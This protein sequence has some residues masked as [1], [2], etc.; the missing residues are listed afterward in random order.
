VLCCG[1][2][3]KQRRCAYDINFSASTASRGRTSTRRK[4]SFTM[5]GSLAAALVV[6]G[7]ALVACA[8]FA[9]MFWR[10]ALL[11][12]LAGKAALEPEGENA[13]ACRTLGRRMA[14]VLMVGCALMA[15]L[16][17]YLAAELTLSPTLAFVASMANNAAF[18]A[19]VIV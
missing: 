4:R 2:V 8:L 16:V 9:F 5:E 3:R 15:T 18:I 12:L 6:T 14:I 7:V 11:Y 1:L 10:G 13:V 17:V 19:L